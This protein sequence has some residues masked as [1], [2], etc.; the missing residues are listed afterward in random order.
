MT[1]NWK[2]GQIKW[3]GK[4]EEGKRKDDAQG[5]AGQFK[6]R[7]QAKEKEIIEMQS[8]KGSDN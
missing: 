8:T 1:I 4:K 3:L 7:I 6:K 5:R 2:D